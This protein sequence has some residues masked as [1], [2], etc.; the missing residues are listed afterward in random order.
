MSFYLRLNF[1]SDSNKSLQNSIIST[2]GQEV[3]SPQYSHC[4][5]CATRLPDYREWS[6]SGG[7]K[8]SWK[9]LIFRALINDAS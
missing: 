3:E 6:V 4:A 1:C 9:K 8:K 5:Q 2:N 7:V